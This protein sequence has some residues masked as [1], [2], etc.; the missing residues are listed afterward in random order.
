VAALRL[1]RPS[2]AEGSV[3]SGHWDVVARELIQEPTG[4]RLQ[5]CEMEMSGGAQ[6]HAHDTE[7]QI[8]FVIEGALVLESAGETLDVSAG[9]GV[10]IPAAVQHGTRNGAD[11]VTTYLVLTY[12]A[13]A[14]Q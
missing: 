7:N 14:S 3:P 12:S 11:G 1:L 5:F 10:F 4:A 13:A 8:F 9:E 2:A 6:P